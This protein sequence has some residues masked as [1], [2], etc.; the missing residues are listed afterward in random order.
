[1]SQQKNWCFTEHDCNVKP[2]DWERRG[3][4]YCVWQ[5]E[6]C[7]SSGKEHLQ[8]FLQF[9]SKQKLSAC[10][11][12]SP[13][14]HWEPAK[15]DVDSNYKYCTKPDT[16]KD[17]PWSFGEP[18]KK[19]ERSDLK[20]CMELIKSGTSVDTLLL[21]EPTA[22]THGRG[23]RDLER[24]VKRHRARDQFMETHLR[25]WQ[26]QTL[27][28]LLTQSDREVLWVCD[29][30]GNSGKTILSNVLEF[31]HNYQVFTGGKFADLA[32]AIDQDRDG[33]AIDLSRCSEEFCCYHFMECIK[34]RRIFST[35][36]DSGTKYLRS[37]R[38]VV[39]ANYSPQL[40]KLSRDRWRILE[41]VKTS[42]SE[43]HAVVQK[44]I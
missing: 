36:Y 34:N 15:G 37:N 41:L 2:F 22:L 29:P 32:Y 33:Y 16:R 38:L 18:V 20:R 35:K 28:L 1:M 23:L 43:H 11:K 14:A 4:T 44:A 8:G 27:D 9:T 5:L 3:I 42:L 7:P 21:E 31:K 6:V 30:V 19:G 26:Q 39:F 10:K 17:G 40:D 12:L 24:V 25:P 13:T